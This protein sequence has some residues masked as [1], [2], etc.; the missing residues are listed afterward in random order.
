M[1]TGRDL[2]V[3]HIRRERPHA[4][5]YQALLDE[6]NTAAM[7][8]FSAAGWHPELVATAETPQADVLARAR[9]AAAVVIMGGEDVD[10]RLYGG[11]SV[12]PGSGKH[13]TAADR[14][15]IAVVHQ[16][17]RRQTPLLGVC[18]GHQ[19]LNVAL[20]GTLV[21]HMHGHRAR[22]EDP[23]VA[24]Q[25]HVEPGAA[26]AFDVGGAARCTHHQ[27]VR[28]IGDGLQVVARAADG[29]VEAVVHRAAPLVG[30]QWHPEHPAVAHR[31]LVDLLDATVAR[32][33][34]AAA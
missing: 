28:A 4:Q 12:Y 18:R 10:P 6:L 7:S 13:E 20:G 23:F 22:G 25:L 16:S 29:T 9:T 1:T 21:E 15:M 8:A 27:A 5:R 24:T 26:A 17:L 33:D 3:L 19:L 2:L 11:V 32:G 30:V 34:R 14:A 31:Q